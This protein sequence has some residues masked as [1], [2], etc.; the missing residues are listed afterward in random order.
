LNR[1]VGRDIG[2]W[3]RG[4]QEGSLKVVELIKSEHFGIK[5]YVELCQQ[6]FDI[7]HRKG[8]IPAIVDVN[9]QWT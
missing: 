6:A 8:R 5:V 2:I 1:V 7:E 4:V 3:G 9:S